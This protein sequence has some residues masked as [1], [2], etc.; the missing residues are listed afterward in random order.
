MKKRRKTLSLLLAVS[1]ALGSF[2]SAPSWSASLGNVQAAEPEK[3]A[4]PILETCGAEGDNITWELVEDP[5]GAVFPEQGPDSQPLCYEL[6]LTGTGEL[7]GNKPWEY[8]CSSITSVTIS[9]GITAIGDYGLSGLYNVT[10]ITLPD[11]VA[12][13][14]AYAFQE[15]HSLETVVCGSGLVKIGDYAFDSLPSL[16]AVTL[17]EGLTEIGSFAFRKCEKMGQIS[18]PESLVTIGESAFERTSLSSITIPGNVE[19][20]GH[21]AFQQSKLN[22]VQL[23]EGLKE[24]GAWAFSFCSNISAISLPESLTAIGD[25]AFWGTSLS[26]ITIPSNVEKIGSS[27][28]PYLFLETIRVAS[29]NQHFLIDSNILYEIAENGSPKRAI[30]YAVSN[31]ASS[32]EILEGTETIDAY[33]FYAAKNLHSAILPE[34]LVSI[35]ENAFGSSGLSELHLPNSLTEIGDYAFSCCQNI[36][37][38]TI[39]N[40]VSILG[41][42]A[43][44]YCPALTAVTIGKSV[45]T[46]TDIFPE[47]PNIT[48]ITVSQENPYLESLENVVYSKDHTKL[49]Y[50]APAKPDTAYHASEQVREIPTGA[51]QHASALKK[52]YLPKALEHINN[53]GIANNPNLDA[54]FFAG[55]CP[56]TD[57]YN[58]AIYQNAKNLI[59]YKLASST[60]WDYPGL[61]PEQTADWDPS[62]TTQDSGSLGGIRWEYTGSEGRLALTG[63][64][65][66]PDFSEGSPAPWNPY[67]GAIQSVKGD[68]ITGIGDYGFCNAS[69]LIQV[70]TNA[71]LEHAG[72]YAFSGCGKLK[73]INISA[74]RTI[75]AAAFAEN[76]SLP[77]NLTLEKVSSMGEG[78]FRGCT[79]LSSATLGSCL[80]GLEKE[81]FESC[82]GLTSFLIPDSVSTIGEGAFRG[83]TS[84]RSVNI[85]SDTY[86]ISAQA[87][88]GDVSLEKVY[89]YGT[90]PANWAADSFEGC[91]SSLNL[92]YR[93]KQTSW[94]NLNGA[95]NGIPLLKQE[96]FYQSGEDHYSFANSAESFGY[97]AGYYFPKQRYWDALGN[98]CLGT[99]YYVISPNWTGS[100]YGMAATTLGFYENPDRFPIATYSPS[101]GTLY[102]IAAPGDKDAPLTQLIESYQISQYHPLIS[103]CAG[104]LNANRN[105]YRGLVQKIEEFERSGGLRAD[106]DAEPLALVLYSDFSGHVVIPVSVSQNAEGDFLITA[107]NPNRPA[108]LDTI[109]INKDFSGIKGSYGSISYVPYR[110]IAA[111]YGMD[112]QSEKAKAQNGAD[113]SLYLSIDKEQG[114]ATDASGNDITGIEGAYEQ[115]PLTDGNGDAFPGIRSFVLPEG[116]YQLS[117]NMPKGGDGDT[118]SVTFYM[119][120]K[121]CFAEVTASDEQAAFTVSETGTQDGALVLELK[122]SSAEAETASFTLVNPQGEERSIEL[123]SSNAAISVETNNTIKIQAPGQESITVDGEQIPLQDGQAAF[124]FPKGTDGEEPDTPDNQTPDPGNSGSNQPGSDNSGSN[125]PGSNNS[126]SN[127]PGSGNTGNPGGKEPGSGNTSNSGNKKPGTGNSTTKNPS[128]PASGSSTTKKP[129]ATKREQAVTSVKV[130]VKKLTLGVGETYTLKASALPANAKDRKLTYAASNKKLTVTSKGKITAKKTGSAKITVKSSNGKKAT[131]QVTIK[132][133]PTKLRLNA[134]TKTIRAGWQFQIKAKF[135]KGTASN[136]LTYTSSRSSVASV[137][138]T[139][140]ITAKK[141]GTATITVKTYNG[142]KAK[143]KI[144]VKK[145]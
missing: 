41:E 46:L 3:D 140:K 64:G 117:A 26:S 114:M 9:E 81:V 144:I 74:I 109:T 10:S 30:V 51:I 2:G 100:C 75:G 11:S 73:S 127:Q 135:P 28:F 101:A 105:D 106:P 25:S 103:G 16:T 141:K 78:A 98:A 24:I 58:R 49:F 107:Y 33:V 60:G 124:P 40:N 35:H 27:P 102:G 44:A 68:G 8:A 137:S 39:P 92:C 133:K 65:Q 120:S 52:L 5:D 119:G 54:I 112:F 88:S 96:R 21:G 32:V 89:F 7:S 99:Y 108:E 121:D 29:G 138:P 136:K 70:E 113:N 145:K 94:A 22:S 67:M 34:S 86:S 62:N 17:N 82:T 13:I 132:K 93:A 128:G 38:V 50:Y 122:S 45:P 116:N 42:E 72:S 19:V 85:P 110:T 142:K 56:T 97:P 139:G 53:W 63:S 130:N 111:M 23:N 131:V 14:G 143:M 57:T 48:D 83:C 6:I 31:T 43:F 77:E 69:K 18:L 4:S 80:T 47:S 61:G 84:L 79:S 123:N 1:L 12:F 71:S 91:H 66:L 20:I 134:K 125:T 129:S 115:K 59:L 90:I 76:T 95:W 87:F 55:N 126:G 37:E 118:N 104:A 15:N 36:Q